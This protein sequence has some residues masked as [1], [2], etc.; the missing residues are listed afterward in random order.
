MNDPELCLISSHISYHTPAPS[1]RVC[2]QRM[3]TYTSACGIALPAPVQVYKDE[4]AFSFATPLAA[5]GLFV[6]LTSWQAF[7][8]Q[9]VELDRERSGNVLYLWQKWHKVGLRGPHTAW[10]QV[11]PVFGVG[12][13]VRL[14]L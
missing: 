9:F 8:A 13:L 7:S 14:A 10:R 4:C 3:H 11:V 5:G 1:P 2:R 6:N 12:A